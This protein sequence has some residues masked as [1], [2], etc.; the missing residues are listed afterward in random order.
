[1]IRQRSR[2][3]YLGFLALCMSACDRV[4]IG[5]GAPNG[6]D[7]KIAVRDVINELTLKV[8]DTYQ[9]PQDTDA[10]TIE[11]W[12]GELRIPLCLGEECRMNI[13]PAEGR[14]IGIQTGYNDN[15]DT[16]N[17]N[18][19]AHRLIWSDNDRRFNKSFEYPTRFGDLL[20]CRY[21]GR[22]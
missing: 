9:D 2:Y 12:H 13:E 18:I 20:F 1:M 22:E 5:P 21:R 3:L 16:D 19:R 8:K 10:S 15:D 4:M 14:V 7:P 11:G 6:D 17:R